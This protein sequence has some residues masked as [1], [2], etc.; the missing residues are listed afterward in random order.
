MLS[1]LLYHEAVSVIMEANCIKMLNDISLF[2][3]AYNTE[4]PLLC[5]IPVMQVSEVNILIVFVYVTGLLL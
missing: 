1:F 4:T 2:R 5:N 3:L